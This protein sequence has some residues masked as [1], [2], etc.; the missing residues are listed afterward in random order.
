MICELCSQ[1]P[2]AYRIDPGSGH[3]LWNAYDG[4]KL[5][6]RQDKTG[7]RVA[8][9]IV[10]P[11]RELLARTVRV[12]PTILVNALGKPWALEGFRASWRIERPTSSADIS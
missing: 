7:V 8:V 12:A 5:K 2:R 9:P 3:A 11:L 10:Q 6:L 1:R 4:E